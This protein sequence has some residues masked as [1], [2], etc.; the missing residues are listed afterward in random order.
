MNYW[1]LKSEPDVYGIT[2]LERDKTTIWDGVRNYQARNFLRTMAVGDR[3]FYYHSNTT[4]PGIIGLAKVVETAI[5]D[6]TQFDPTHKYYDPKSTPASPRWQTVKL[7]FDQA[8]T[9]I[10]TLET[11]R[12]TF[13]PED[14]LVVR[15][16]NR[17][18]VIPVSQTVAQQI[19]EMAK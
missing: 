17:L 18:S 14:F 12:Q 11:L 4:P 3:A 2:D 6:P 13:T 10:I 5:D 15:P 16:G 7:G 1:L 8:F 19:L 9:Q